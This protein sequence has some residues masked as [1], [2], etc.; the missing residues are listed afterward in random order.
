MFNNNSLRKTEH[1]IVQLNPNS[2]FPWHY[3]VRSIKTV[4][5]VLQSDRYS[6]V[7]TLLSLLRPVFFYFLISKR[8]DKERTKMHILI[9]QSL[10]TVQNLQQEAWEISFTFNLGFRLYSL[11]INMNLNLRCTRENIWR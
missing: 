3:T 4:F 5:Y 6:T 7:K 1:N 8:S 9:K 2:A 10:Y 11:M